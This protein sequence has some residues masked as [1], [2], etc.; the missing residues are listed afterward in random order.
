MSTKM[1][2]AL[3]VVMLRSIMSMSSASIWRNIRRWPTAARPID[4]VW[5]FYKRAVANKVR[6]LIGKHV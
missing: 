1:E 6:W 2:V 3:L 4:I 5:L